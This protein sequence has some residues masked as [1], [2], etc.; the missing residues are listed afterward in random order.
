MLK[1]NSDV[2]V[3]KV[4]IVEDFKLRLPQCSAQRQQMNNSG[5]REE[6]PGQPITHFVCQASGLPSD[7]T[8]Y[9]TDF[10]CTF[11]VTCERKKP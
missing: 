3:L 1:Q 5:N 11:S 4:H 2:W 7:R 8:L 9:V 6:T 10:N